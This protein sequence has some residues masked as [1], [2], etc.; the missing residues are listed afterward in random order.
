[1][2]QI[3]GQGATFAKGLTTQ[4]FTSNNGITIE[5]GGLLVSSGD[6]TILSG[7]LQVEAGGAVI[8]NSDGTEPAVDITASSGTFT[9]SVLR[10]TSARSAD[11]SFNLFEAVAD[12]TTVFTVEGTG[13]V[14]A[15][16]AVEVSSG[17]MNV[18]G[19]LVVT[20]GATIAT[21]GIAIDHNSDSTP[22]LFVHASDTATFGSDV[23]LG[24][25]TRTKNAAFDLLDLSAAGTDLFRVSGT[26]ATTI[27]EGGLDVD[28]GG[29]T[30]QAGG[31]VVDSG[32]TITAGG[33]I[34]DAG[35]LTV[36]TGGMYVSP[37]RGCR[38]RSGSHPLLCVWLC[39]CV[40]GLTQS[41]GR[42]RLASNLRR[43]HHPGALPGNHARVVRPHR[44]GRVS[45]AGWHLPRVQ[46]P[47]S[48]RG[49]QH[50]ACPAW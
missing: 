18:A 22:P 26:G 8:T 45:V 30:V 23:I 41:C 38:A 37:L 35:G 48:T 25:T 14:T 46:P 10:V 24:T 44:A 33:L 11:A 9:N 4:T 20:G 49:R 15:A 42:W 16:G 50:A 31:F 2:V 32:E 17:G 19:D 39:G 36:T 13:K 7:S 1:M 28:A 3:T 21:D 40:C 6:V 5:G 12:S 47:A 29:M 27:Y 34:I 43:H